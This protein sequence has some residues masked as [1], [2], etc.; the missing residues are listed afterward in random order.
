MET[1]PNA[2]ILRQSPGGNPVLQTVSLPEN[3]L[4]NGW[5]QAKGL[6]EEKD[7]FKFRQI[8]KDVYYSTHPDMR[9]AGYA[10]STMWRFLNAM[11]IGDFVVVPATGGMFYVAQITG[12]PSY[13]D[14]PTAVAQD[15]GYRR[16]V[17]WLNGKQPISRKL[18]KS[19]LNSRMKTQQTSAEASDL[20]DEI[21]VA[22]DQAAATTDQQPQIAIDTL[23]DKELRLKMI[24]LALSEIHQGFMNERKFEHL[25]KKLVEAVGATKVEIVPRLKDKGVD[26]I[27][28]FP[29]GPI[30]QI[31][32]GIQV[33]YYQGETGTYAIDQL[34]QGLTEE[35]LTQGW[36]ISSGVFSAEVERYLQTKLEGS[37]LEV[38]LIDG[39]QLAGMIV[40]C[41]LEGIR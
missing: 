5:A 7:Y 36:V 15:C 4:I 6:I 39:E 41:G 24:K 23:F 37:S 27:A 17:N 18:A 40:D 38:S 11:K 20:I 22:L 25:V 28:T 35:N 9:L 3:I 16:P 14:D 31:G 8:L 1:S 12:D 2:Y 29:V 30:S 19:K 10:A 34:L 13:K 32:V 33:K 21:H 26:I